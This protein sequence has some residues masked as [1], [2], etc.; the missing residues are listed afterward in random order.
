MS[1]NN[2]TTSHIIDDDNIIINHKPVFDI[3][4]I[5]DHY[6][7]KDGTEIKYICTSEI[8]GSNTPIDVFF[9]ETP[10]PKFGNKYFGIYLDSISNQTMITNADDIEN[11]EFTML[12]DDDKFYYSRYRHDFYRISETKAI[13]GGRAYC[14]FIGDGCNDWKIITLRLINGQFINV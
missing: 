11:D 2:V 7:E 4:K 9:R 5:I 8:S 6:S 1:N 3:S 12:E 10:H 13:D 14:R